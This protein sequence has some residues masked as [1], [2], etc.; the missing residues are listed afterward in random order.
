MFKKEHTRDSLQKIF[1]ESKLD[2]IDVFW[3]LIK[4]QETKFK[5]DNILIPENIKSQI[6]EIKSCYKDGIKACELLQEDPTISIEQNVIGITRM[7]DNIWRGAIDG[8]VKA[9]ILSSKIASQNE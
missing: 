5:N 8:I 9:R 3:A 6:E 4:A 2:S 1:E 7:N